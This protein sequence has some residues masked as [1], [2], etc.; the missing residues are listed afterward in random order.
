MSTNAIIGKLQGDGTVRSVYLH[1]DGY[2][3]HAGRIL[4]TFYRTEKRIDPAGAGQTS[5]P[6]LYPGLRTQGE[7]RE[8][9]NFPQQGAL[10]RGR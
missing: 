2:F 10:P 1:H 7:G 9:R 3:S 6:G 5:L 4:R 8:S